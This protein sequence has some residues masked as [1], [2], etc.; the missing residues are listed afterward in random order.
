MSSLIKRIV[1]SAVFISLSVAAIFMPSKWLFIV[2]VEAF[3]LIALDEFFRIAI[4]KGIAVNRVLGLSFGALLPL[5]FAYPVDLFILVVACLSIFAFNF[6]RNLLNQALL[7]T[8]VTLFG[9]FYV[10]WFLSHLTK[11]EYLSGWWVFY[12]ILVVK[13]GDAGAYFIGK[14]FGRV[15]LIEHISPNKSV[16]GA[17]GGFLT[18]VVLSLAAKIF[19]PAVPMAH[20][21]V[22]GVMSAVLAQLGDLAESLIKRDAGVKD[23]GHVPGLGGILDIMDSVIPTAPFVFY[24]VTVVLRGGL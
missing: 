2:V 11:L 14:N 17:V 9:I 7:N 21:A 6:R 23:S 10:A 8:S 13:G 1:F 20:L 15:K 3:I 5:P 12:L 4:Q 19:F 24:Y 18:S 22:L 16:E